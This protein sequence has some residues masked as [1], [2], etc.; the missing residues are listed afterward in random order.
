MTNRA[1]REYEARHFAKLP[2]VDGREMSDT[3]PNPGSTEAIAQGC[4]CPV[5]DN[6]HGRG[7]GRIG[8]DGLPV[9]WISADCQVHGG[10]DCEIVIYREEPSK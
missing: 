3:R 2:K 4:K 1:A 7:S 8:S 10:G 6:G 9:F 5:L